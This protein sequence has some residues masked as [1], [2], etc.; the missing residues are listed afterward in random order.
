MRFSTRARYGM[1]A[2]LALAL[3]HG[4]G[5]VMAKEIGQQQGVPINY[6]EQLLAQLAKAKLVSSTRGAHGGYVLARPPEEISAM[7]V[8]GVLEGPLDLAECH[9]GV[10]CTRAPEACALRDLWC[11]GSQAL[12]NTFQETSLAELARRQQAKDSNHLPMYSI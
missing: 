8:V 4:Q 12:V 1:R 2:M 6:L 3:A 7:D 9:A 11:A 10:V 5:P